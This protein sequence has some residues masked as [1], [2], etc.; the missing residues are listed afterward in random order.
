MEPQ[1]Y[2]DASNCP[3]FPN[4]ELRPGERYSHVI[5]YRFAVRGSA[6]IDDEGT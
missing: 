5:E 1:G 4:N 6:G 3:A 2:P